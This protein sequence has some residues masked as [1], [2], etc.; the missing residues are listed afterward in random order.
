MQTL[1][2]ST[3]ST[4]QFLS[5][6]YFKK[7]SSKTE[8]SNMEKSPYQFVRNTISYSLCSKWSPFAQ[9]FACLLCRPYVLCCCRTSC[10]QMSI[11]RRS[12]SS[13]ERDQSLS[14]NFSNNFL[15]LKPLLCL[16]TLISIPSSLI[17]IIAFY[18]NKTRHK[19]VTNIMS[20]SVT[21]P[22]VSVLMGIFHIGKFCFKVPFFKKLLL[23]NHAVNFVEICNVCARKALIEGAKRIINSD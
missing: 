15:A 18:V 3:K 21:L 22:A 11:C 23:R 5:N 14:G 13:A 6:S 9:T 4:A 10:L 17:K 19:N 1:Q 2:I 12:Q 16:K 7:W 8:V 20:L